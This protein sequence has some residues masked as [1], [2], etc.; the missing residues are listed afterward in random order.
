M[1][2]EQGVNNLEIFIRHREAGGWSKETPF[3]YNSPAYSVGHPALSYDQSRIYFTSDMPGGMGGKDLYVC[4]RN[5]MGGWSEPKNLGFPINTEGDEMFPYVFQNTLY[6]SSDGHLGLG[7]LDLFRCTIRAN[8]HGIVENLSAPVNSTSDDFGMCLDAR[9]ERGFFTSDRDGALG[10]ENIYWFQMNSRP[11]DER[12]WSGRAL[13]IADAKPIPYLTVRLLDMERNELDRSI[14]GIN[15]E[16]EFPAPNVP[17]SVS[18]KIP[19]GATVELQASDFN[20]SA[21][22]D[23]ELPDIYMNSVMD[24]PVNAIIRDAATDEWLEGVTVSVKDARDGTLLFNGITNDVGITQGQI[25]DRRFG[26]DMNLEVSFSRPGYL[27]KIIYADIRVLMFM[28]QALTGPEGSG[29]S[30]IS[31]G[32]DMGQAMNLRPIYFDYREFGIRS[33]AAK[34]LDLVVTVM[35]MDPSITIDLRSHTDGT[36]QHGGERCAQPTKGGQFKELR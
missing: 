2:S 8:D 36:G 7:G 16:F 22:G 19:G 33:D 17:A 26:E 14:T 12:K 24:L 5:E 27:S 6:F 35:K 31:A 18:A 32:V 13:D 29:L 34:E 21:F 10:A 4:L 11:E 20:V 15:G 30:A 23:T 9:G 25:P 3:P 28:E 1:L